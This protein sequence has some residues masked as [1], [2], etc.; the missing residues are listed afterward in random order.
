[1]KAQHD[2]S[3]YLGRLRYFIDLTNPLNLFASEATL[4]EAKGVVDKY[5]KSPIQA[6]S[7]K[8]ASLFWKS[9]ILLDSTFHP[10]TGEKV[11]LP[12]RMA[13]FVPT[14][15]PIIALMLVPNPSVGLIVGSQWLNQS[16]NVAFNFANA[17]KSVPMSTKETALAYSAAVVSSCSIALGMNYWVE[18]KS[19]IKWRSLLSR[20]VPFVAVAAAGTLNVFLMRRKELVDGISVQD[21]NGDLVEAGKSR[22]AGQTAI[23]QVAVSRIVTAA[24]ALFIPSLIMARLEKT[25]FMQKRPYLSIPMNLLTVSV[26]LLVALPFA[27]ALFPSQA[28]LPVHK[29]EKDFHN[30]KKRDGTPIERVFFNK[31]L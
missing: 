26:S 2:Q 4:T 17:N 18:N 6:L 22:I 24:P 16:V 7:E 23:T 10:Q 19:P 9:K 31:G 30:V 28:S 11:F 29:L 14:N 13:S 12:F 1:M 15:V 8:E 27:I 3:T 5:E 25:K 21:D 20:A